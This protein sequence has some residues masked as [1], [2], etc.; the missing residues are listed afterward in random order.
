MAQLKTFNG[1]LCPLPKS[2]KCLKVSYAL[3]PIYFFIS[4]PIL[5]SKLLTHLEI[6]EHIILGPWTY[7]SHFQ[8]PFSL[9]QPWLLA[10]KKSGLI[11]STHLRVSPNISS[12]IQEAFPNFP[13]L[14]LV[15]LLWTSFDL[16]FLKHTLAIYPIIYYDPWS[17]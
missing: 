3:A 5:N 10:P 16:Y 11:L 8:Q 13:I 9:L 15:P 14:G 4:C 6:T 17:W 1:V 12:S 2:L 7:W